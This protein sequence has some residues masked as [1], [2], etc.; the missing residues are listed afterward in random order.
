MEAAQLALER[1]DPDQ[2]PP[3][4]DMVA[5]IADEV[6]TVPLPGRS[7]EIEA[8]AQQDERE[9]IAAALHALT[10]DDLSEVEALP[11]CRVLHAHEAREWTDRVAERWPIYEK[12]WWNPITT[13]SRSRRSCP[14]TPGR[15]LCTSAGVD[16]LIFASHEAATALGG[17][18]MAAVKSEWP[19]W[20][21]TRWTGF[22]W[23]GR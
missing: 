12:S 14:S 18:L 19:E 6:L 20:E 9:I 13:R 3:V 1:L 17:T 8:Q 21:T 15:S 5:G 7:D 4:D 16:W 2:L 11:Y 22:D 10:T 23:S